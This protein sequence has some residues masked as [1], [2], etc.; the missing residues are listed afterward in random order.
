[1]HAMS[2]RKNTHRV[3]AQNIHARA[4]QGQLDLESKLVV[5]GLDARRHATPEH[6]HSALQIR[7]ALVRVVVQAAAVYLK[8]SLAPGRLDKYPQSNTN[9]QR[10]VN[11]CRK[12][13]A[14]FAHQLRHIS[15]S[16]YSHPSNVDMA[17]GRK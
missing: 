8:V 11:I 1:M 4:S 16:L 12:R 13:K 5:F 15:P 17:S 7:L 2:T 10:L 14:S 3:S 6:W 9:D